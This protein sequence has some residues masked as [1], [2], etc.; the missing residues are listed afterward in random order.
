M[1]NANLEDLID[2]QD[3]R[4]QKTNQKSGDEEMATWKPGKGLEKE[5]N[6]DVRSKV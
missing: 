6:N 1:S 4:T 2:L 3:I 5:E